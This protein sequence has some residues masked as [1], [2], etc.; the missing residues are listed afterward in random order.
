MKATE[1]ELITMTAPTLRVLLKE[2]FNV[3]SGI[4]RTAKLDLVTMVL[5]KSEKAEGVEKTKEMFKAI[6]SDTSEN[7]VNKSDLLRR[8]I[9][10]RARAHET[11]NSGDLIKF[12]EETHTI[13]M[14]RQFIVNVR[15]RYLTAF[16]E[17][18]KD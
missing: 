2:K 3:M 6:V 1:K 7:K 16:P 12:M 10:R 17:L 5:E 14:S 11:L 9:K 8:E 18:L 13:E 15:N 4:S